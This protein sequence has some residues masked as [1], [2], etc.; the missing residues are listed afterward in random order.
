MDRS[1]IEP[2]A[3]SAGVSLTFVADVAELRSSDGRPW[4]LAIL[5]LDAP[6]ALTA[7]PE[8][9]RG[10]TVCFG[11]HVDRDRLAAAR[12]AGCSEVVSRSVFFRRL[13]ALLND[14]GEPQ[15]GE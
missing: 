12:E 4:D 10:R 14:G 5:D 11:S 7:V 2:R 15:S 9:S 3:T 1:R 8:L 13:L 6:S